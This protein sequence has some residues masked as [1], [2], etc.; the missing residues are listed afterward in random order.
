MRFPDFES[1]R[2]RLVD[3]LGRGPRRLQFGAF[4]FEPD[5]RELRGPKG[6]VRLPPQPATLLQLL[7]ENSGA[8]VTREQVRRRLWPDDIHVEFDQSMNTCVKRIRAALED[9]AETPRFVETLPRLGH[10]FLAPVTE[11]PGGDGLLTV[12]GGRRWRRTRLAIVA[13]LAVV[14]LTAAAFGWR[15]LTGPPCG[16]GDE[17]RQ[18]VGVGGP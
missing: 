15:A 3:R 2:S 10:R 13:A 12:R 8:V 4:E 17:P 14:G 11:I 18:V 9:R 7:L 6:A 5:T 1:R 16:G